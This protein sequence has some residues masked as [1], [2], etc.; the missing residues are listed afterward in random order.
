MIYC[1]QRCHRHFGRVRRALRTHFATT[2]RARNRMWSYYYVSSIARC[3]GVTYVDG[4]R[5]GVRL[6]QGIDH[7]PGICH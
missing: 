1:D 6:L 4:P 3:V 5:G 7:A 2:W